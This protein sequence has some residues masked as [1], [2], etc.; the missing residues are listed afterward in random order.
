M[1]FGSIWEVKVA[2][3]SIVLRDLL[4]SSLHEPRTR[5]QNWGGD[6]FPPNSS[7]ELI[8]FFS[9]APPATTASAKLGCTQ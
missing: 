7:T 5:T 3:D 4:D 9:E 2:E 6:I 8:R 1:L